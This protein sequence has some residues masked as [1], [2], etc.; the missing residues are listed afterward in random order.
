MGALLHFGFFRDEGGALAAILNMTQN[1]ETVRL[2]RW[3]WAA[4]IY[5]TRPLAV[6]ACRGGKVRIAGDKAK[7]SHKVKIGETI[8]AQTEAMKKTVKVLG[9]AEKRVGAKL[10]ETLLEDLTPPEERELKQVSM[11]QVILKRERGTGRP[12][13]KD[14]RQM[15]SFM[16][17]GFGD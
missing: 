10:V 13:K 14:R 5:K 2:D 6:E 11:A 7:P 9:L 4:R 17:T 1:L 16:D 15:D 12:T 3:L 8:V